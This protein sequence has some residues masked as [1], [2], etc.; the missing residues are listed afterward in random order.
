MCCSTNLAVKK[1]LMFKG[2]LGSIRFSIFFTQTLTLTVPKHDLRIDLIQQ[3][4]ES[5]RHPEYDQAQF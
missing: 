1:L 4:F 5:S 3:T 2:F